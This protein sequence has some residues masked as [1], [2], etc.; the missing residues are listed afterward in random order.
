MLNRFDRGSYTE[1]RADRV[2]AVWERWLARRRAEGCNVEPFLRVTGCSA[3]RNILRL[4][5][6]PPPPGWKYRSQLEISDL[7][8]E[9]GP[10]EL[11]EPD[12]TEFPPGHPGK[13]AE[14]ARRLASGKE[15]H[16]P[17]DA[18]CETA[19]QSTLA[20]MPSSLGKRAARHRV[21][22]PAETVA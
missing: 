20:S 7:G 4:H 5:L 19:P 15:L 18:T 12:P 16:H 10:I 1:E 17:Q 3:R 8:F 2:A 13:I 14:M 21:L 6:D 9:D 11:E 22:R